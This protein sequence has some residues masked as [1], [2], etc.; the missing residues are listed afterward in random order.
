[1]W[2]ELRRELY[3]KGLEIVTVALDTGGAEAARPWIER[4]KPEH[5]SLIDRAHVVDELFGIVNVPSGVWIDEAGLIVRPPETAYP[6]RPAFVDRPI[7]PDASPEVA[8]RVAEVKKLRIE[9][10]K[11]IAALRDWVERGAASRYALAPEEVLR[12]SRPRPVEEATAAAHFELGQHLHRA[13]RPEAAVPHFREAHRLQP[14]NWTY[15]RQAWTLVD[16]VQ[17][18]NAVYEGD[19]LTDVRKIGAENYYPPLDME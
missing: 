9:A 18:P 1:M 13:G 19:W 14:D 6:R 11:Y 5:P 3:P 16:P 10:D 4:A 8:A 2:Q 12:R 7:P 15:K 17:G